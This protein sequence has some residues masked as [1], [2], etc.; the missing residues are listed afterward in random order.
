MKGPFFHD[1]HKLLFQ[2]LRAH[3]RGCWKR[4]APENK[5]QNL[6]YL[7]VTKLKKKAEDI[8]WE[9]ALTD[10]MEKLMKKDAEF[11]EVKYKMTMMIRD[12][13]HF[14]IPQHAIKYGDVGLMKNMLP[15]LFFCFHRGSSPKYAVEML[16]LIQSFEKEWPQE[17]Q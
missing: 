16:E 15:H 13:L 2:I 11:N 10:A 12:L 5:L 1:I 8:Y 14:L 3:L 4:V 6:H 7:T 9:Y 17:I